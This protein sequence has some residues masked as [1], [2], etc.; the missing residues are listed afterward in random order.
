M[1][2]P[3]LAAL[4]P[5]CAII[6]CG[7][8]GCAGHTEM[9]YAG[10]PPAGL[11]LPQVAHLTQAV[12][13]EFHS[14]QN[15]ADFAADLALQAC[16]ASGTEGQ[17]VPI[18]QS[19]SGSS[20][21]DT[22]YSLYRLKLDPATV[23]AT[24]SLVWNG[25]EPETCWI[26]LADWQKLVWRWQLAPAGGNLELADP[27][28]FSDASQR[29]YAAVIVTG[30]TP[31][32][33]A[34]IGFGPEPPPPPPTGDGYTLFTP[35][36][37]RDTFLIDMA[38]TVVH[39]WNHTERANFSAVLLE[40]GH[41]LRTGM[42]NGPGFGAGAGGRI[43]EYDWDGKMLW[44]YDLHSAT[45]CLHHDF[46]FLPNGHILAI[47]WHAYSK[48]E[49]IA[50]GRDPATLNSD[51][52]WLDDV[53]ELEPNGDADA[54]IVWEWK[55]ADHLIQDF[56]DKLPDYGD[57]A[58]HPELI[59]LNFDDAN[60]ATDF[61]H[62]NG[63]YYNAELDQMIISV[64]EFSEFWIIDH[65]TTKEE[66]ASHSGGRYG[67]GGDLLYRWGNPE[68]YGAGTSADRQLFLQHDAHWIED[69]LPGAGNLLMY[70]NQAGTP[71]G[72][73]YSTIV[74]ITPPCNP[75]G[76]YFLGLQGGAYGPVAPTWVY[77]ADPPG[78]FYSPA[79]S[80]AQRL[81][82]GDTLICCGG[83]GWLFEVTPAGE[84]VWQYT[85]SPPVQIARCVRYPLDYPGVAA[86]VEE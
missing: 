33:L 63:V 11:N 80:G 51:G 37:T 14:Q 48:A 3:T 24:L 46:R 70:N 75:D 27:T 68:A 54:N 1:S 71:T 21:L 44:H 65:S 69:G 25:A 7:S 28:Q 62:T 43:A 9:K 49:C 13:D 2:R 12:A 50:M 79:I 6:A 45:Q 34:T 35:F 42:T 61:E 32:S 57:P 38:G 81:V 72:E 58:Q 55:S 31:A 29:C 4:L 86:L 19:A 5:L 16:A 83:S 73:T 15:G 18:P 82:D 17:F 47:C 23:P 56:S 74:E 78:S 20:V 66:A 26:G 22:A 41:L 60:H 40:N 85:A 64:H 30:D 36:M 77:K 53:L 10:G 84:I 8:L 76:S 52:L 67:R 59:D 39:T